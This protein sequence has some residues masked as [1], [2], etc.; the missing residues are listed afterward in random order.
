MVHHENGVAVPVSSADTRRLV[1]VSLLGTSLVWYDFFLYVD[2]SVVVFRHQFFPF[3]APFADVLTFVGLYGAGLVARPAGGMLFGHIGDRFGRRPV[4]VATL[5]LTGV[6]TGL[7]GLLPAYQR[8][9]LA[10]PVLLVILRLLQGLG[11][12]GAWG[13]AAVVSLECAPPD[14]R[15]RIS[16]WAQAGA[17]AGNLLAFGMMTAVSA[18]MSPARFVLWGWRLSFLLSAVLVVVGLWAR[19]RIV[20]TPAFRE[21]SSTG[22]RCRRPFAELLREHRAGLATAV[23]VAVGADVVLFTFSFGYVLGFLRIAGLGFPSLLVLAVLAPLALVMLIP[24]FGAVSDRCGRRAVC[25][26]GTA[27]TAAWVA[28]FLPLIQARSL[29]VLVP[30]C[31]GGLVAFAAMYAPQAALISE[32]F[33]GRVRLSG[34]STGYQLAGLLGGTLSTMATQVTSWLADPGTTLV[35]VL[36]ALA[37]TTGALVLVP[38][39]EAREGVPA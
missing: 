33:P 35:Y 6:C 32:L 30:A 25:L 9:G 38:R 23:A 4:L 18:S 17:P 37:V 27:G 39:H 24:V 1:V 15:G 28:V 26:A 29:S 7:I 22:G 5:L 31:V 3:L 12:G 10:A 34:V 8:I 21:L 13:A 19:V 36:A 20:E 16:S 2:A 11:L 14:R